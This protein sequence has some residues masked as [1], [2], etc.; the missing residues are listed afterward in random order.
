MAD[1]GWSDLHVVFTTILWGTNFSIWQALELVFTSNL[2]IASQRLC[3]QFQ[4]SVT[5]NS[6]LV[7]SRAQRFMVKTTQKS[8]LLW[9]A[10]FCFIVYYQCIITLL[11]GIS[12][13]I[14][15]ICQY[16]LN[17]YYAINV[18]KVLKNILFA[19]TV[20]HEQCCDEY[21]TYTE[22]RS[23][24]DTAIEFALLTF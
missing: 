8:D 22:R 23:A 24:S 17:V 3:T 18:A 21:S 14:A 12:S 15:S 9:S 11:Q 16:T 6:E 13:L 19:L 10:I 2:Q 4:G 1:Q 7:D 20:R 5:G